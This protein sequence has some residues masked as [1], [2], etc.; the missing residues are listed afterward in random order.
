M[1]HTVVAEIQK[2]IEEIQ[3]LG[4]KNAD[5]LWVVKFG[6]IVRDDRCADIFEGLV[7]TLRAAKKRGVVEY[8]GEMLLQGMSDQVDIVLKKLTVE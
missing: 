4:T 1:S 6:V 5:G 2:L 7:G 8:A 3:R